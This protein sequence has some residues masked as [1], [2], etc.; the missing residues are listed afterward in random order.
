[1]GNLVL[2]N[3]VLAAITSLAERLKETGDFL[4]ESKLKIRTKNFKFDREELY[5][6][7]S[8]H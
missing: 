8:P 5:D 7:K 2:D 4:L 1:M 6:R 3:Q